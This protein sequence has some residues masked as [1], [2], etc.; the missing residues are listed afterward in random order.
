MTMQS[1]GLA[2]TA[3]G[4]VQISRLV[5]ERQHSAQAALPR[6]PALLVDSVSMSGA[7]LAPIAVLA[8]VMGAWRLGADLGWTGPFFINEGLLSRY[9]LWFAIAVGAHTSSTILNRW[10]A[11]K[12]LQG[13]RYASGRGGKPAVP[14]TSPPV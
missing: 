11:G 1:I 14:A 2:S 13:R 10:V 7:V 6:G 9:Q 12:D 4:R 5:R 8:G 3:V